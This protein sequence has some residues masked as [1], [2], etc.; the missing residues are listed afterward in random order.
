MG[1][2]Q[3]LPEKHGGGGT[4]DACQ[5]AGGINYMPVFD[6]LFVRQRDE[7]SCGV[8]CLAT[9]ARLY[10]VVETDYDALRVLLNPCPDMGSCHLKMAEVS[11]DLLP[12]AGVGEDCYAGGIAVAYIFDEDEDH[13]VVFLSQQGDEVIY[14]DPYEHRIFIKNRAA[15]NGV[16]TLRSL[17]N[18]VVNF[19]PLE[20]ASFAEWKRFMALM[21][22]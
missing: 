10:G 14:Y 11:R 7:Y 17:K 18:W 5:G 21:A 16:A 9:V 12:F 15:I 13:Y 19:Q 4:G 6:D 3:T 8:A 22:V 1:G 20:G 2:D